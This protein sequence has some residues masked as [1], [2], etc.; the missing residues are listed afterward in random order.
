M[1]GHETHDASLFAVAVIHFYPVFEPAV[2]L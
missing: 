1:T 2:F